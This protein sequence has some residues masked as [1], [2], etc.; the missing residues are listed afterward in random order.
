MVKRSTAFTAK[1][2]KPQL[3]R[4]TVT[5]SSAE[6]FTEAF[7][8]TPLIAEAGLVMEIL[9]VFFYTALDNDEITIVALDVI[10]VA[11]YDRSQEAVPRIS[12]VGTVMADRLG[13]DATTNGCAWWTTRE[14]D[15]TD[16]AGNGLLYG[17]KSIYL[18]IEGTSVANPARVDC[19]ILYRLVPV[20][21][22]ELIGLMAD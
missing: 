18:G 11:L 20:N 14:F 6:T 5:E 9:K 16:G 3:M 10:K 2:I 17:K 12:D 19:A 15:L 13:H 22:T 21:P 4:I 1:D 7:V 8:A